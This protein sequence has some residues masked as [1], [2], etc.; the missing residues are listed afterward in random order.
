MFT[1]RLQHSSPHLIQMTHNTIILILH[2]SSTL[3]AF[4][5]WLLPPPSNRK[6]SW[7]Y[8]THNLNFEFNTIISSNFNFTYFISIAIPHTKRIEYMFYF[9]STFC[10]SFQI[11]M[12]L[13]VDI[14]YLIWCSNLSYANIIICK[15]I[16][17]THVYMK[18]HVKYISLYGVYVM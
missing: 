10:F 7:L 11:C 17:C 9:I 5:C 18:K 12:S 8:N 3:S 15:L 6:S 16:K 4:R 14:F 2:K 13:F 1:I